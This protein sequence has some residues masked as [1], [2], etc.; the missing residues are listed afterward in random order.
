MT[1]LVSYERALAA[2]SEALQATAVETV[3][4]SRD[5]LQ[6]IKL[7]AK[8]I[9]DRALLADATEF[10]MRVERRLGVLLAA[11]KEAGHL[12]DKGRRAKP[13][14]G[15]IAPATLAEIGVDAKLSMKAQRAAAMETEVFESV[16]AGM[17]QRMASGKA[18]LVDP[19]DQATK[20]ASDDKRRTDHA[21]RALAGGT[22]ADLHQLARSGAKFRSI[23][24]DPQWKFLTRSAGGEGRSAN[25]HYTTEEVDKIKNL[26]VE[27]LADEDCALYMWMLDWCP[28]DALDLL[29]HYGF[30]HITT[31][32]TWLKLNESGNGWHMGMGYW[33]RANP[34][35][36]Y[37][38]TRGNPKR[39]NGDVRQE[40]I[41]PVME[42]SRK[43]DE[44]LA[45]V[46]RL[47]EG[48]YLELQARRPRPGWTS[49]GN[50]LEF[51]GV[52]A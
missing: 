33:T 8:Q 27:A 4:A 22:V 11:A 24:M 50:E 7:R 2:M 45:R 10:Q 32:F 51:T 52:A 14:E 48:P 37:F 9:R 25:L 44:W 35:Q 3:L 21:A 15:A 18:I 5:Q 38:A 16:V 26:P 42:H 6:H 49:W 47:T 19:I 40:I 34:E 20:A 12:A 30:K 31:A 46:E 17:R 13:E 28:Q 29:K 1:L 39:L 36:C 41:A 23:G 43:P